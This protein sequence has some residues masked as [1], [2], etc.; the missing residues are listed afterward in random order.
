MPFQHPLRVAEDWATLDHLGRG[1]VDVGVGRGNQPK[2][3]TGFDLT[4]H[5]AEQRFSEALDII[6]RAWT[7]ESF[8]Y[9]GQYWKFPE[10]LRPAETLYQATSAHMAGS[11]Q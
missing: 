8:S 11:H 4:L 9:D 2:E 1:R 6:R 7:E 10:T 5:E 3:F